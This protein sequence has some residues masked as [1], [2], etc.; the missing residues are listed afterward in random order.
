[1]TVGKN[2]KHW[3]QM[4]QMAVNMHKSG[5][6]QSIIR[7]KFMLVMFITLFSFSSLRSSSSHAASFW[8]CVRVRSRTC[9]A[10]ST[11]PVLKLLCPAMKPTPTT[12]T[13]PQ[14][15]RYPTCIHT[16][17][18]TPH[19]L[20]CEAISNQ[21]NGFAWCHFPAE[22]WF[23]DSAKSHSVRSQQLQARFCRSTP[24]EAGPVETAHRLETYTI[25]VHMR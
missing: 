24:E 16:Y 21:F 5:C 9:V 19:M 6:R 12:R 13:T 17:T 20:L 11:H 4:R 3:T 25:N 15:L 10:C 18:H 8:V 14:S 7:C 2:K 22:Q 23:A 1:M